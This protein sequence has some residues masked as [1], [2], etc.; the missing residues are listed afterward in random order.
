MRLHLL[1]VVATLGQ[2]GAFAGGWELSYNVAP[3][4]SERL[5]YVGATFATDISDGGRITGFVFPGAGSPYGGYQAAFAYHPST[6]FVDLGNI[7]G[8]SLSAYGINDLG[9]ICGQARQSGRQ[10]S[11][12]FTPGS[13][14]ALLDSGSENERIGANAVNTRGTVTGNVDVGDGRAHAYRYSLDA[15]L[16][17]LGTLGGA[18]SYGY[19]INDAGWVVGTSELADGSWHAFLYR[20]DLGMLDLGPG[21]ASGINN[22]GVAAGIS[23]GRPVLF[24]DGAIIP[25]G[26]GLGLFGYVSDINDQGV[27]VGGYDDLQTGWRHTFVGTETDGLVDLTSLIDPASG[28]RVPDAL[29]INNAGQ[30]VGIGAYQGSAWAVRLD[31]VP[32]PSTWALFGLGAALLWAVHRRRSKRRGGL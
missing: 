7:P 27:V 15:G 22:R 13:G 25:L 3:V 12:V 1:F 20:D 28:W 17:D 11:F 8:Y 29:G 16:E 5:P 10:W 6:G 31:P 30:I 9:Q 14:F 21:Y 19:A 2:T 32:E 23:D 24:R 26:G 18:N 4:E